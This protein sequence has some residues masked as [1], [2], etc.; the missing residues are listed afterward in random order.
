MSS[1]LVKALLQDL[2]ALLDVTQLLAIALN[3]V[4]DIGQLAGCVHLQLFQH[5]LLTLA[6]EAVEPLKGVADSRAQTLGR[7]LKERGKRR[8]NLCQAIYSCNYETV[9]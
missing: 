3:L 8:L 4:L 1:R 5:A 9:K 2:D 7:G 6:Q